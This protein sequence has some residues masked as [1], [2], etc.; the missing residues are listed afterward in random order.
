MN[1]TLI[2]LKSFLISRPLI[3]FYRVTSFGILSVILVSLTTLI[4]Q[5]NLS[6]EVN[7]TLI[8]LLTGTINAVDKYRRD[9]LTN[10]Q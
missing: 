9:L 4:P 7:G 8:L 6:T 10:E 5:M 2:S 3:R 1:K